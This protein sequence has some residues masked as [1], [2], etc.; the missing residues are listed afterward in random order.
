VLVTGHTGFKGA[1]LSLWLSQL[2][3]EVHG[4]ALDPPSTP[5]LF[6]E[7]GIESLVATS[8]QGDVR[9][10]QAVSAAFAAA[11]PTHLFHLAAQPL[12]RTGHETPVLTFDT[13]VLGTVNVLE[14]ARSCADLRAAVIVTSDKCYDNMEQGHAYTEG[15]ALGGS[16]PYSASKGAAEIVT[17]SYR[18]SFLQAAGIGVATARA[19]NVIGG[20]DW[21]LDR[22]IPDSIRAL[23]AGR[24]AT[25][26]NPAAVRPWQHVLEP[27]DGY[28]R[29]GALLADD[30]I[31]YAGAWNFGPSIE[32]H[33]DVGGLVD[34]VV[35]QWGT[36]SWRVEPVA[37][38][39][40]EAQLLHLDSTKARARL[41][42]S[43][44]WNVEAAI[45]AT[46]DWYR[47]RHDGRGVAELTRAQIQQFQQ[48]ANAA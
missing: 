42:W 21:A 34:R 2:G 46:V 23:E 20:G 40:H 43:P 13:N 22:V 1:W 18:D 31:E 38:A 7:A 30:P 19:G 12:V 11:R 27:L 29:L 16:D 45:T 5:S 37:D 25:I 47:Q 35:E 32:G 14:A 15:D 44:T 48:I 26:R 3:A 17:A 41:G 8:T 24:P 4:F 6:V 9:D 10:A 28:L 36:G 39:V 33:L